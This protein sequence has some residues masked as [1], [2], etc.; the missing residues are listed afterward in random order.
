MLIRYCIILLTAFLRMLKLK[1]CKIW[2]RYSN[3]II[4]VFVFRPLLV[5][6][7]KICCAITL[8]KYMCTGILTSQNIQFAYS[9]IDSRIMLYIYMLN[10]FLLN[11]KML[12]SLAS[13]VKKT[14]NLN[15]FLS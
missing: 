8:N 6:H 7:Q 2:Q 15:I 13:S 11:G 9:R 4:L 10:T 1:L 12:P 5:K 3:I 14:T